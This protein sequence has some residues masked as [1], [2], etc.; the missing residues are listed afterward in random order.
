MVSSDMN[1]WNAGGQAV[2]HRSVFS[3]LRTTSDK[4]VDFMGRHLREDGDASPIIQVG[5]EW[6]S[7]R[8]I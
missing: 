7:T 4:I 6:A 5:M 3:P 8:N 1:D 2:E